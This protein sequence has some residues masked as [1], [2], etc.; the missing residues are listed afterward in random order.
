MVIPVSCRSV[1]DKITTDFYDSVTS[2]I[3]QFRN[4][5]RI[6]FTYHKTVARIETPTMKQALCRIIYLV[7]ISRM[8]EDTQQ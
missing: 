6:K 3:K 1:C 4:A 5:F 7:P 8:A 2:N